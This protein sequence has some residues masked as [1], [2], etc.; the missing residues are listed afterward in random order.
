MVTWKFTR[1]IKL[2]WTF[3]RWNYNSCSIAIF[4]I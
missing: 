4:K 2:Y 1:K 3:F